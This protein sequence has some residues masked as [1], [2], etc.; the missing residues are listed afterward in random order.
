MLSQT[1]IELIHREIDGA[2]RPAESAACRA[3]LEQDPEARALAADLRRLTALVE[4]VGEREPPP[5]LKRAILAALPPPART[6]LQTES[7]LQR[8]LFQLRLA[9]ERME[10]AIMTKKTM[11]IGGT[12]LA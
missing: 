12:A 11:L 8:F 2:N 6:S 4:R 9:T 5:R 1:Q 3:L 7:F 10:A